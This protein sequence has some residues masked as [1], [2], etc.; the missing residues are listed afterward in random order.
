NSKS[1]KY[2]KQPGSFG[3]TAAV[4]LVLVIA[5]AK[6][7]TSIIEYTGII[8]VPEAKASLKPGFEF[9]I[10]TNQGFSKQELDILKSLDS[11]RV[12]LK[13]RSERLDDK[14]KELEDRDRAYAAKLTELRE[15]TERLNIEREKDQ[16]KKSGK[17]EQLANVYGSMNPN[18]AAELMEQLDV[19]IALS[20]IQRMPEKRIGQILAMMSPERALILTKMLSESAK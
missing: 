17:L 6:I 3:R 10:P 5:C 20:L 9:K 16:R 19:T 1:I 4:L 15:L 11:R 18:E 12:E 13:E 2:P 14:E 7:G 8:S